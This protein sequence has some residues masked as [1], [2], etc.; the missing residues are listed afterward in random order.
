MSVRAIVLNAS[1]NVGTLI[2]EGKARDPCALKGERTGHIQ[3]L[4]N[5]PFGHKIALQDIR[6]GTEIIKY[7]LVIG[8]ATEDIS[9]GGHVHV[10]NVESLRG[11]GDIAN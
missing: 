2:Q 10:H 11:R 6:A 7:G 3:L 8:R 4:S 5:L 1:D 9:A